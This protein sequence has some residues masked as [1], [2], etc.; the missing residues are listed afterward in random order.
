VPY[1]SH[2]LSF[3]KG[4]HKAPELVGLNPRGKVPILRDG[5]Y[6]LY[7]SLAILT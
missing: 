7:E 1:E 5:A 4:E 3:S 6:G 2:L